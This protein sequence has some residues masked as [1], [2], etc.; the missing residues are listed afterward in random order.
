MGSEMCIRDRFRSSYEQLLSK[1]N[2]ERL[3]ERRMNACAAFAAKLEQSERFN[4]LF[5]QNVYPENMANLRNVKRYKEEFARTRRL[6]NSP[7][8]NMRR[9]MNEY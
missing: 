5:P 3:S 9:I 7:L 6:F 8:Y 2:I 4:Y 1:A